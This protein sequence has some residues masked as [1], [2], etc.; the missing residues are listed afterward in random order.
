MRDDRAGRLGAARLTELLVNVALVDREVTR[1]AERIAVQP[2]EPRD[3]GGVDHRGLDEANAADGYGVWRVRRRLLL[4]TFAFVLL[5]AVATLSFGL[6]WNAASKGCTSTETTVRISGQTQVVQG[7]E[8]IARNGNSI[9]VKQ[10]DEVHTT[11]VT[12]CR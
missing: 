1:R 6:G 11:T 12:T 8:A 3:N 7:A 9:L 2:C 4:A 10:P 5:A